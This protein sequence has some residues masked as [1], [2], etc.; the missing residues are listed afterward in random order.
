MSTVSIPALGTYLNVA[1][2]SE[3]NDNLYSTE[4][5]SGKKINGYLDATNLGASAVVGETEIRDQTLANG[6][7]VGQT[8]NLDYPF[9]A[10]SGDDATNITNYR[11][12]PGA[13]QTFYLP[14]D[15]SAVIITWNVEFMNSLELE[16][17]SA[18]FNA[19]LVVDGQVVPAQNREFPKARKGSS[20]AQVGQ[21]SVARDSRWSGHSVHTT[22]TKGFH[23]VGVHIFIT[24]GTVRVRVRNIKVI[25]F[26]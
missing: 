9:P 6:L 16:N 26:K 3:I 23:S 13:T 19:K 25:W 14:Y 18:K 8:T 15:A 21:R 1:T 22:M 10:F 4:A 2:A 20:N 5:A 17:N 11:A 24:L 7:M 12:V